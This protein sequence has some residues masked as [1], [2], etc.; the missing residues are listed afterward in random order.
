M[1]LNNLLLVVGAAT[2]FFAAAGCASGTE[3]EGSGTGAASTGGSSSSGG[4]G[5]GSQGGSSQGGGS[6]GGGAQG[7]TGGTSCE[8][9]CDQDDDDVLDDDDECPDTPAGEPVND[10]GCADSQVDPELQDDFPPYG[11]TWTPTG[12]LGRPGGLTWTYT[13]I[14][15]ADL[16]HIYWVLCDDPA[17]P[18]GVSLDGPIDTMGEEWQFSAVDSDLPG[19]MMVFYNATNIAL[20]DGSSPAVTGRLTMTMVGAGGVPI[21]FADLATLGVSGLDGEYGAEI[22]G[23]GFTIV[24]IVEVEDGPAWTPYLD[25]FDA[26]ATADPGPG[27]A[28]SFGGSFYDE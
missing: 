17:T 16:F 3:I 12:D 13:G 9:M 14:D 11:L 5:G 15:D 18:C 4:D 6:Q 28:V 7:G 25:Y 19:G 20:E 24:A 26:A 8:P 10:V 23:T 2:A 27:S 21:P 1:S 22:P